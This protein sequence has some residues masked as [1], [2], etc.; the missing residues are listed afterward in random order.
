MSGTGGL[1]F[2]GFSFIQLSGVNPS[3][4][5]F[6]LEVELLPTTQ[7]PHMVLVEDTSSSKFEL[8]INTSQ[9][10]LQ[11]NIDGTITSTAG[12]TLS[13]ELLPHSISFSVEYSS[14]NH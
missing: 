13:S 14:L 10:L 7:I 5:G 6:A 9:N 8:T 3:L 11:T 1:S 12:C 4:R 2:D